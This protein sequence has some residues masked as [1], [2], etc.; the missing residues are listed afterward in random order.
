LANG[1][2]HFAVLYARAFSEELEQAIGA[3]LQKGFFQ[4]AS[5]RFAI[6]DGGIRFCLDGITELPEKRLENT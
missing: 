6:S 1:E 4:V 3:W 5:I 2:V